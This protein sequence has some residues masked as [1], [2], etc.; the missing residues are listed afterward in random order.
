M[1]FGETKDM[2][3]IIHQRLLYI[4]LPRLS[5]KIIQK[6]LFVNLMLEQIGNDKENCN[7]NV[8]WEEIHNIIFEKISKNYKEIYF[9]SIKQSIKITLCNFMNYFRDIKIIKPNSI[10]I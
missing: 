2:L 5:L 9:E 8:I 4:M 7:Q 10:I 6:E 3:N 1:L